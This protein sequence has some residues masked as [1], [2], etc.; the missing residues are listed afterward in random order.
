MEIRLICFF[1]AFFLLG[2]GLLEE[3]SQRVRPADVLLDSYHS[4]ARPGNSISRQNETLTAIDS[5][6]LGKADLLEDQLRCPRM[7][8]VR[9]FEDQRVHA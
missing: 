4:P 2:L 8:R 9:Y 6:P 1:I 7:I 5:V 3:L